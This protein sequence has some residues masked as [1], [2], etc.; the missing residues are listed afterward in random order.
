MLAFN[1]HQFH[2]R[3]AE[4]ADD[5]DTR[6]APRNLNVVA[7]IDG[8]LRRTTRPAPD[9]TRLPPGITMNDI[10]RSQYN[11]HKRHHGIKYQNISLPNGLIAA[12]YGPMDGRRADPFILRVSGVIPLLPLMND[13]IEDYRLFGDA[14]Y[15]MLWQLFRM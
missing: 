6:G 8:T 12:C 2:A 13:G 4:Y 3:L 7:F 14:I 15:P 9:P 11:G 10:Q 5:I 1:P